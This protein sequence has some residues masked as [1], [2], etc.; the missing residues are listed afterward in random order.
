MTET[1]DISDIDFETYDIPAPLPDRQFDNKTTQY[2]KVIRLKERNIFML[3]QDLILRN[4]LQ[5]LKKDSEE[6]LAPGKLGAV[7]ARAGVGKTAFIVQIALNTLLQHK[8]VLHISLNEPV[9]KVNIWY[10]EVF[11]CVANHYKIPQIQKL[12]DA[13]VPHRFIMT[14]QVEGFSSPKLEERLTDLTAQSIFLPDIILI[15]GLPF[16][17]DLTDDLQALKKLAEKQ[18]VP[19]WF[20]MN[21]HRHEEPA[22]DGLPIQ[23]HRVQDL[24]DLAIALQ[25]EGKTIHVK[26]LKGVTVED[27]KGALMLDPETMLILGQD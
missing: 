15:D 8:N 25:P 13:I 26:A 3:I 7:L 9:G 2:S 24:F 21:I 1:I 20:T 11:G 14:F 5:L 4:P 27:T 17:K 23:L 6:I 18:K 10:K 19:M 12:W 16:E 22:A